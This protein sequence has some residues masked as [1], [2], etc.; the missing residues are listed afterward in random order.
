VRRLGRAV[1]CGAACAALATPV[2]AGE[3]PRPRAPE[4]SHPG[5][6]VQSV[7]QNLNYPTALVFESERR[8]VFAERLTGRIRHIERGILQPD[9][10]A[11]LEVAAG[12]EQGLLGLAVHPDFA[13]THFLYAYCTS[14]NP[15]RNRVVRLRERDGRAEEQRVILDGLTAAAARNGGGLRFGPDGKLYVG[16][17]DA[18]DH[19]ASQDP[20]VPTG[21]IL[22]MNPNGS[23][24]ADNQQPG[25]LVH[26]LGFG[27]ASGFAFHPLTGR[28]FAADSGSDRGEELNLIRPGGNYG[29]AKAVGPMRD[30]R[31]INPVLTYR[32]PSGFSNLAFYTGLRYP[33]AFRFNLFLGEYATGLIR[34]VVLRYPDYAQVER[35]EVF[36]KA[37]GPV[38]DLAD[39]PDG[40]LYFATPT[41]IYRIVSTGK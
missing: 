30:A 29:W 9:P 34:R 38:T 37:P 27:N 4:R 17:G 18:G 15:L 21:K 32:T 2:L 6:E 10:L 8:I 25:S 13:A 12:A 11:A 40:F 5:F 35:S 39:G 1:L 14:P 7:W 3:L 16:V 33:P 36:L 20:A 28:L 26:A 19:N 31:F 22:R 41:G 23:V 24:P